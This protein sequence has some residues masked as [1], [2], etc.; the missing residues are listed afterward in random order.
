MSPHTPTDV[1]GSCPGALSATLRIGA[2]HPLLPGHFP[3][4]P[5]VPGVL[6]LDAVVLALAQL[7]QRPLRLA[8][9]DDVR[10]HAPL[11]PEQAATLSAEVAIGDGGWQVIGEWANASGRLCAFRLR[12]AAI[13]AA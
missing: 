10:F 8:A 6:M 5:L 13:A 11:L 1:A 12:V 7:L 4:A 9:V 2:E 3:N